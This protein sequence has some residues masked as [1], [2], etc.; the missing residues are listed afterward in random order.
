LLIPRSGRARRTPLALLA[1]TGLLTGAVT[2]LGTSSASGASTAAAGGSIPSPNGKYIVQLVDA[3]IAGYTGDRAGLPATKPAPGAKID[4]GSTEVQRYSSYLTASHDRVL[5]KVSGATKLYDYSYAFNGFAAKMS[6]KAAFR[7]SKTPGVVA[8]TA[9]ET[10][11]LETTRTPDFLGLS[12]PGGLWSQLGG[13]GRGGAGDG[14]IVGIIDSGIWPESKSFADLPDTAASNAAKRRFNGVCQRGERWTLED[15]NGKIIGARYFVEGFG[16]DEIIDEDFLS[17]RDGD[18]HGSHTASTAAGNNNVNAVV[19]GASLGR[20]SGMAPNALVSSY[21][22][23]WNGDLGGCNTLDS[24]EAIDTAVEDG[25]DVLNYSISGSRTSFLDPVEVAFLFAADAGVFVATSAGNSGP[26]PSTVA[27]NSP[28]LTSTAAGTTDRVFRASVTL[29]NGRTFRGVGLGEAVPSR[30]AILSS[31]AGKTGADPAEVALCYPGTLAPAKVSGKIVQCDRGVIGRTDKSLAVQQAGGVGMILTNLAPS[32][33]NADLHFVPTVHLDEVAGAAVKSYLASAT[34]P[35]ARLSEGQQVL[36]A[37]APLVAEFSSRGPALAGGGDVLKPDIMAPGVDILASVA[38]P[39]NNGR[40]FDFYS[41]TSMSSPHIAGIGALMKQAHPT[42]SPMMIKSALQTTA[43]QLTNKGRPIPG[44][45]HDFGAGHVTPNS[46]VR[47]G[48]VYDSGIVDWI[49]FLCGTGE[50]PEDNPNCV[51][52]GSIDPSNLNMATISIGELAGKQTVTRT[53]TNVGP[54]TTSYGVQVQAPKGIKVSVY[55]TVLRVPAGGKATYRAT[56]TRTTAAFD[57][58]AYGAI[59]LASSA[60]KVRSTVAVKPVRLAAPSEAVGVGARGNTRIEVTP[61][62]NGTLGTRP[63]GLVPARV[64]AKT[65]R[66]ANG[67]GFQGCG[68]TRPATAKYTVTVPAGTTL[69]RLATYD[70][71]FRAGTDLDLFVCQGATLIALSA[72]GTSDEVIDF[73]RPAP[74][75]Y[76]VYVDAFAIP[77]GDSVVAKLNTFLLGNTKA[78]NFSVTPASQTA[79]LGQPTTVTA[80]WRGLNTSTRYLGRITYTD[81]SRPIGATVL[82]VTP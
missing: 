41:G 67:S 74:G 62:Y 50:L 29:G 24:V 13:P 32:S 37:A 77:G 51:N 42:W 26:T 52:L 44:T 11:K 63:A 58:Y 43:S 72:G 8:V 25:V 78:A 23:C 15:C 71:D 28:W 33:I 81:G 80:S 82:T 2:A 31:R 46:A 53:V 35:T 76:D 14:T 6:A 21:K 22:V 34:R 36:N 1:L 12:K 55:P 57:R 60:N 75:K 38:P 18:G 49:R 7:L 61:G 47:P 79:R 40:N 65:V 30:P 20:T 56:F 4:S 59:T 73:V 17:P 16:R 48:L 19:E 69:A 9:D 70:E 68:V 45:P 5:G 64:G 54:R 3:P 39:F 27:H 66:D 10:R